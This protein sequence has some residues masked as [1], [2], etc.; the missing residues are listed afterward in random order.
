MIDVNKHLLYYD[1]L[2]SSHKGKYY[3]IFDKWK[4]IFIQFHCAIVTMF[5]IMYVPTNNVN[6]LPS[7]VLLRIVRIVLIIKTVLGNH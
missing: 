2:M 1:V 5:L 4:E 6:T 3:N 7:F